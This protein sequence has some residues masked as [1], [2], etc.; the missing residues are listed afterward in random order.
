MESLPNITVV[1]H[2]PKS[3]YFWIINPPISFFYFWR[4]EV[5]RAEAGDKCPVLAYSSDSEGLIVNSAAAAGTA[6][7]PP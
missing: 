6:V 2:G 4:L 1:R 7:R 5:R 3:A